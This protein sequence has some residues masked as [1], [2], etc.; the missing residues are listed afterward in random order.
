MVALKF[1]RPVSDSIDLAK[2]E[3]RGR[4]LH[5]SGSELEG[6]YRQSYLV[7]RVADSAHTTTKFVDLMKISLAG[8]GPHISKNEGENLCRIMPCEQEVL[9]L[10]I[11]KVVEY[12]LSST[13]TLCRLHEFVCIV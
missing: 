11:R 1:T 7:Q 8:N 13:A 4:T 5:R 3:L 2:E 10:E 9:N 12:C 6:Y